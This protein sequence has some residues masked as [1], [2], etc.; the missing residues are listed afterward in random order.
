MPSTYLRSRYTDLS[1]FTIVNDS[2]INRQKVLELADFYVLMRPRVG[3]AIASVPQSIDLVELRWT[4]DAVKQL[5]TRVLFD[6]GI[7]AI[8][9]GKRFS[10]QARKK[11][12]FSDKRIQQKKASAL[13]QQ[14]GKI[15]ERNGIE[16]FSESESV[17]NSLFRHIRNSI[18]HGNLFKLPYQRILFLDKSG[19]KA[20]T[21]YVITTPGR[22]YKFMEQLKEGR[23]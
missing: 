20:F 9:A 23:H 5:A 10:A 14:D 15:V 2:N 7:E 18:A 8:W 16:H 13:V 19:S 22:L 21:A 4:K 6:D 11:G 1:S 12:F 3:G 17:A